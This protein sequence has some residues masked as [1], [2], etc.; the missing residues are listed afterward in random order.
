[1]DDTGMTHAD[2]VGLVE[3]VLVTWGEDLEFGVPAI[4]NEHKRLMELANQVYTMVK[5]EDDPKVLM[6]AFSELREYA[7]RHFTQEEE[8]MVRMD[9]PETVDHRRQHQI[10][11]ERLDALAKDY[12]TGAP[13]RGIDVIGLLGNW[14][15]SHIKGSDGKVAQFAAA[16]KSGN[17]TKSQALPRQAA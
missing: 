1:M 5:T 9:Y 14:W 16:R 10:F 2:K 6:A 11:I 12:R 17:Q 4:D 8:F 7:S 3:D 15:Q 13:I